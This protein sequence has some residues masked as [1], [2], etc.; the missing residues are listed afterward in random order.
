M[1]ADRGAWLGSKEELAVYSEL[2]RIGKQPG[3]D[4]HYQSPLWG[5]RRRERGSFILDFLFIQ[6]PPGLAINVQGAYWHYEQGRATIA[7]DKLLRA[8]LAGQGITLIFIDAEDANNRLRY[9]VR[10][11]L[12]FKDH[13]QIGR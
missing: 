5:G 6:N 7:R 10:E 4:F 2:L 3:L 13:S 1:V 8:Q 11:A 9:I 12:N